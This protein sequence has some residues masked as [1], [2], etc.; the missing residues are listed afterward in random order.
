[1]AVGQLTLS[2]LRLTLLPFLLMLTLSSIQ[3]TAQTLDQVS[4]IQAASP[5]YPQE[6]ISPKEITGDVRINVQIDPNGVVVSARAIGGHPTFIKV[7]ESAARRWVFST[8]DT[9]S[10]M[11]TT[12]LF[13]KFR[14]I[15]YK[16]PD[17]LGPIFKPPYEVEVRAGHPVIISRETSLKAKRHR[18]RH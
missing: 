1:M 15:D 2:K 4:V 5:L 18:R 13:F 9:Q 10:V 17:E 14:I 16:T 7:A 12:Q 6:L 3:S 8:I 11:R